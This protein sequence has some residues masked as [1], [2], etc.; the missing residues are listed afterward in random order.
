MTDQ[1]VKLTGRIRKRVFGD[2]ETYEGVFSDS[3]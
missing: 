3:L 2:V 1:S